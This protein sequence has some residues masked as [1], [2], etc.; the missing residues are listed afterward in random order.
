MSGYL[1]GLPRRADGTPRND[2]RG[3]EEKG[4]KGRGMPHPYTVLAQDFCHCEER[5]PEATKQ[6]LQPR[7][8]RRRAAEVGVISGCL[9]GLPR[10]AYGTPRN[11]S[12]AYEEKG[13]KGRGMPRPSAVE[14]PHVGAFPL[15]TFVRR[16][17]FNSL[18]NIT[19]IPRMLDLYKKLSL[20][21]SLCY[22][23]ILCKVKV[24]RELFSEWEMGLITVE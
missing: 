5:V 18:S 12:R 3:Y 16:S 14:M 6:S 4:K 13:K 8:A 7:S 1:R 22:A 21:S 10:R 11:D 9:R 15:M 20:V 24:F 17:L 2:S 23:T 19:K